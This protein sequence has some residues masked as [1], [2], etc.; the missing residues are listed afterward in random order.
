MAYST[1]S[2]DTS[3]AY[4]RLNCLATGSVPG[5]LSLPDGTTASYTAV[6]SNA[7]PVVTITSTGQA[8]GFTRR[9]RAKL[10]VAGPTAMLAPYPVQV[11]SWQE[12][13][14]AG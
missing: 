8:D 14:G 6:I 13:V 3:N 10:V 11:V 9:L 2:R 1:I 7:Y 5:S 4:V 12:V